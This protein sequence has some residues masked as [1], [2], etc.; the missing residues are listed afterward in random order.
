[1]DNGLI[2]GHAYSITKVKLVREILT[3]CICIQNISLKY[4]NSIDN[5]YDIS[6]SLVLESE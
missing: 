5:R 1:M 2:K 3:F 4:P 6:N